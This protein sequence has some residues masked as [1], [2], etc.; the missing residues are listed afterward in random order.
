MTWIAVA[1]ALVACGSSSVVQTAKHGDLAALKRE[2]KAEQRS[3]ALDEDTVVEL[4]AA[5]AG[6]EVRSAKGHAALV[7]IRSVRPCAAS[8]LPVLEERAQR[9]DE[10]GAEATLMLLELGQRSSATEL[11]RHR[12]AK[13]G[14]WR[15]VAAR[16]AVAPKHGL[17]RREWMRDPDERVRRGAL[18][19]AAQAAQADDIE[20]L[21]EAAR[22]DPDPESRGLAAEAVGQSGGQRA[23]LA[24]DDLWARAEEPLR[25]RIVRAWAMPAA[26]KS[27]GRERL[28][29]IVETA[30]GMPA[31][32]AA[33]A[34][35]RKEGAAAQT[36]VAALLR[37]VT[38]G[39]PAE[40]S[41]AIRVAP[42]DDADVVKA[43][44]KS[45]KER[46]LEVKVMALARLVEVDAKHAEALKGLRELAKKDDDVALQARAALAAAGDR[47]VIPSLE[48]QLAARRA[49]DR[50]SAAIALMRLGEWPHV[51]TALA[52]DDPMVRTSVACRVLSR[53]SG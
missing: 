5:I 12:D 38:E 33:E 28:V 27:G 52:D 8:I 2:I 9:E 10:I 29:R 7:R 16:A 46:D 35:S 21:L 40:R 22:L 17:L 3:G 43:L 41:V 42:L 15:A 6:R 1:V 36:G 30:R 45:G 50:K 25:E 39:T 24:L 44:E 14:A 37:A 48:K 53:D 26:Y 49:F 34:L 18:K 13:D 31:L 19:A 32:W 11:E 51:A 20:A 4:A 47:G 23:V